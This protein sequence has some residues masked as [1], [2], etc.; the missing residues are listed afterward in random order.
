[1]S[2]AFGYVR[3]VRNPG[4]AALNM[5]YVA[6]GKFDLFFT[7]SLC[8]WDAAAG[9]LIVEEAGGKVTNSKNERWAINDKTCA[10]TNKKLHNRFVELLKC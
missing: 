7:L 4:S 5:C 6:S 9:F 3:G 8:S 2:K 10:S 1:L